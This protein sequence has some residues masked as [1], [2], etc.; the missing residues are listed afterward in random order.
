MK[1]YIISTMMLLLFAGCKKSILDLYPLTA[2]NVKDFYKSSTDFQYAVT[3]LYATLRTEGIVNEFVLGDLPT[4]DTYTASG[5]LIAGEPDYDNLTVFPSTSAAST[6]LANRWN[7]CYVGVNRANKIIGQI[8]PIAMDAALKKQYK[9]EADFFRAFYYFTLIKTFGDVPLVTSSLATV[10]ESY[11]YGRESKVKIYAQIQQD[12]TEAIS[13]LP[14]TYTSTDL[15]RV[16][17]V[18]AKA[19]LGRVL[20]FQSKFAEA[21]PIL[22]SAIDNPGTYGLVTTGYATI[23]AYNNGGNKEILF[24][25]Q[26]SGAVVGQQS[27]ITNVFSQTNFPTPDVYAAFE[28]GDLRRDVSILGIPGTTGVVRKFIDPVTGQLGG[29]DNPIIRFSDV[30]LMY[31]ECLNEAGDVPGALPYINQVRARAFGNTTHN[32]QNTNPAIASTYVS[33]QTDLRDKIL[34]ERRLE[35]CFEGQRFWDLVRT[36]HF[37]ILNAYFSNS[38]ILV[39]GSIEQIKDYQKLY[40]VPQSIL[41]INPSKYT[42][43]PGY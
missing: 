39:N 4:D 22:K 35:F 5:R 2:G 34:K 41:D 6:I 42:Q 27:G 24:A 12:L 1:K 31:A 14:A 32:Y 30:L 43:N 15:G 23:F 37:D 21:A 28:A 8:D 13:L 40:P 9:G 33:G 7:N 26:Y 11:D 3:G 16:S 17:S 10:S 38:K 36:N 19:L 18:S 29:M 25:N 20:L